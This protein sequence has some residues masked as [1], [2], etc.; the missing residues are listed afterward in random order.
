MEYR[1]KRPFFA[2]Y[3][4]WILVIV[5]FF[6]PFALR[7]A[8]Q[9]ISNMK[10]EVKDWLPSSFE[11]TAQMDWF[12]RHFTGE[13]FVVVSWDGCTADDESFR[14]LQ[15]KLRLELPPSK[16]ALK[17]TPEADLAAAVSAPTMS[18]EP[19]QSTHTKIESTAALASEQLERPGK[20]IGDQLGLFSTDQ[21]YLNWGGR[22]EK[23]L[24]GTDRSWYFITPSG[25]LY[26]WNG[27]DAPLASLVGR[28]WRA[29]TGGVVSGDHVVSLGPV[30]GPWYH[31]NPRRLNA[32]LFKSIT[33]GPSA[34]AALT[35]PGGALEGNLAEAKRRLS[36]LLYG[37]DGRQT[38][39]LLTLTDAGLA[40]FHRVLG[41]G[42]L[43]RPRGRLL[44]LAEESGVTPQQLR[45]GGPPVDN[46]AI[47]EEGSITLVR[48]VTL[49][50]ILGVVLAYACFRT[51]S[52]TI[53]V[54]FVGGI[55]AVMSLAIVRLCGSS[56]DAVL[57]SMPAL[58]YVLGIS[59]AVH[60]INYYH[61]AVE[62]HGLSGA[63]SRALVHGWKPALLCSVTTALGLGSLYTSDI[64]P[65]RK[66]GVYSA[67]SV[68]ATLLVLFTYLPAALE[69]WPQP[70]RRDS[71]N[72]A[73]SWWER[74]LGSFWEWFGGGIIRHHWTV[75]AACLLVI[76]SVGYGVTRIQTSVNLLK[77]FD[78]QSKILQDYA[79]LEEHLGRLVPME[80]VVRFD[81]Q[82]QTQSAADRAVL[83]QAD[84]LPSCRQLSFLDRMDLVAQVQQTVEEEFG[85]RGRDVAGNS[86]SA[87][88]FA[89]VLPNASGGTLTF[90]RRGATSA[91]LEAHRQDFLRSDFLCVDEAD[92][93]EL[94]RISLRI[95]ALKDVDYG[96][97]VSQL[98]QAIEP[99][100]VAQHQ[101]EAVLR[102]IADHRPDHRFAGARVCLLGVCSEDFGQPQGDVVDH[103]TAFSR[104][105]SSRIFVRTL[106][107]LLTS[108]RLRVD[109]HDP[110][111]TKSVEALAQRLQDYDCVVLVRDH[112]LY[113]SD[114]IRQGPRAFLDLHDDLAA[115][116]GVTGGRKAIAL[117]AAA[118]RPG[119]TAIYTGVVPIVYKAQRMLL[120]SLIES[121]FW[122][123][124]TITPLMMFLS[125]GVGAGIVAMLPNALP[126]FVIFGAMGWMRIQ[127][128]IGSMMTASIALGVAVDDTIHYLTWYREELA[129]RSDRRQAILA[130]YKRCAT[131]TFQAA[132]I[133]GLG[134]SIFACSTFVP[135]Q[136]FG[137]LM[138][139]I[140]LAGM[141]AELV[142]FPALLAGPLGRVFRPLRSSA[143]GKKR[144]SSEE[145]S[146]GLLA[147]NIG[148]PAHLPLPAGH[149]SGRP[150]KVRS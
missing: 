55:S 116:T 21:L 100:M 99:V 132:L 48:L 71:R 28:W 81:H 120:N 88:T 31:Q 126:V 79:W 91:Q 142:F 98:K 75:A 4:L 95:G 27:S 2:R 103:P 109:C 23:W 16:S 38:C 19:T 59:G 108:S 11:E 64:I 82:W 128:D 96:Q 141:V 106:R 135:T 136:R 63:T 146:R 85:P 87:L 104:V 12:W 147:D 32:Q 124:V 47:D 29:L 22:Q 148:S 129:I 67:I 5:W 45:I 53:I 119:V 57:M 127:V 69:L 131:P 102:T 149:L 145:D 15:A 76:G 150:V 58:V 18:P 65:I 117:D 133:S 122:S 51:I 144:P 113:L 94:W 74:K 110:S 83:K 46:L 7:G 49:S 10:N 42:M 86:L 30:D 1:M 93:A 90:A 137:Y 123:F 66:F 97:F 78:S 77:L 138:L 125:R 114:R 6:V 115:A 140:I 17:S 25:D 52:A 60:L 43:G 13:R 130:A 26:R 89:P 143:V 37:A 56:V 111:R 54:F 134:L 34:L 33:T 36:G 68:M 92:Q 35:G 3:A 84:P 112:P 41:R 139:T 9:G 40:D 14:L 121:T 50:G 24:Q 70:P 20:F 8:R 101:R 80:V 73:P 39:L 105:N 62:D 61:D 107:H 44:D 72:R 118:E